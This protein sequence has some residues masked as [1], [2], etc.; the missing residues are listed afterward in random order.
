M[1]MYKLIGSSKSASEVIYTESNATI[2]MVTGYLKAG[3]TY[4][5]LPMIT[6]P[7]LIITCIRYF[8]ADLERD[9]FLLPFLVWCPFDWKTPLGYAMLL[10]LEVGP[11]YYTAATCVCSLSFAIGFSLIMISFAEDIHGDLLAL[12]NHIEIKN[13]D[14]EFSR[15]FFE[16]LEF[17]STALQLSQRTN[18]LI[19]NDF[20]NLSISRLIRKFNSICSEIFT[21]FFMWTGATICDTLLEV[22][23]E[24]VRK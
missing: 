21:L 16:I 17:H 24:W 19:C 18:Q 23:L 20:M 22:Q 4:I 3:V 15:R 9:A 1:F 11:C 8:I 13:G 2:E 12:D 14:L 7:F 6:L 10:V 5:T